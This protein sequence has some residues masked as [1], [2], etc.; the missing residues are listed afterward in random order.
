[1]GAQGDGNTTEAAADQRTRRNQQ[2]ML[3]LD[4]GLTEGGGCARQTKS[5]SFWEESRKDEVWSQN[6]STW[7]VARRQGQGS[8]CRPVQGKPWPTMK[9]SPPG[10]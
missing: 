7:A 10:P 9:V 5:R 8:A 1:M 3:P 2:E 6:H 4:M